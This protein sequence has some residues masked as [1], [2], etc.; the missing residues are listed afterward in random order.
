VGFDACL[1]AAW[2]VAATLAP[3]AEYL[4]ASEE[5]EPG[6]G[7]DW[8]AL[9]TIAQNPAVD[10]VTA[11]RDIIKGFMAQATTEKT[12]DAVTMGLI[13]LY[14]LNALGKALDAIAAAF[15]GTATMATAFARAQNQALPF[16]AS[17][18]PSEAQN[19]IDI[20]SFAHELAAAAP[21]LAGLETQVTSAL[22]SAVVT[23]S[24]GAGRSRATGMAIYFPANKAVYRAGYDSVPAAA[25]W[26]ALLKAYFGSSAASSVV[27]TFTN[28]NKAA[29]THTA[30][31]G[32]FVVDGTLQA[33]T[34]AAVSRATLDYGLLTDTRLIIV[35][36]EPATV[37]GTTV[38]GSWDLTA[39]T[40][41]QGT[42][43]GYGTAIISQVDDT[44]VSLSIVFAYRESA[45]AAP[46]SCVRQLVFVVDAGGNFTLSSDAYY[47]QVSGV[48]GELSPVAGSTLMPE[49][50]VI[51]IASGN[52]TLED[53]AT[54]AFT[55][56]PG[57]TGQ[58][59][60]LAIAT[61]TFISGTKLF[62]GLT[63]ENAAGDADSVIGTVVV[64]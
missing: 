35:G 5:T 18:D 41:T 6:H 29:A 49:V 48:F 31:D 20:G 46:Q 36:E 30:A 43:V 60:D 33:D 39:I 23:H 38:E 50:E 10:P 12:V 54:T 3:H 9:Q 61:T 11:A 15:D 26:R 52:E 59:F 44:H 58:Q 28:P 27:P 57:A 63:V 8:S 34:V 4:V 16:G 62:A 24:Q 53:G 13:D 51:D 2:E 22:G 45:A 42:N 32:S 1:M 17:P 25:S 21:S 47:V 64:P 56:T 19:L 14:H 40:L 55:P 7:W 37:S